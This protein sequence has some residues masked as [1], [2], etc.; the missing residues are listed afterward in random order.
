MGGLGSKG[1]F[2]SKELRILGDLGHL[3]GFRAS[4]LGCSDFLEAVLT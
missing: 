3:R 4:S 1:G 2:G